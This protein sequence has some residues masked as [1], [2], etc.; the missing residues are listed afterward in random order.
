MVYMTCN[1]YGHELEAKLVG[2]RGSK[3]SVLSRVGPWKL[4]WVAIMHDRSMC[5]SDMVS[6]IL[7]EN[8]WKQ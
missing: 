7:I 3:V 6:N 8:T 5:A 4:R 2:P 1:F